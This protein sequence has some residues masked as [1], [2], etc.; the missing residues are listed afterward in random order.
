M[1]ICQQLPKI[2]SSLLP[3]CSSRREMCLHNCFSSACQNGLT[4]SVTPLQTPLEQ[5]TLEKLEMN[6]RKLLWD[7]RKLGQLF[8]LI[9]ILA[10]NC[11]F[12]SVFCILYTQKAYCTPSWMAWA[13]KPKHVNCIDIKV[14]LKRGGRVT[15]AVQN[16]ESCRSIWFSNKKG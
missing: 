5:A 3:L 15:A 10:K 7:Y 9:K 16:W 14:L 2:H 1:I 6:F 4:G 11:C 8:P 12:H 13:F